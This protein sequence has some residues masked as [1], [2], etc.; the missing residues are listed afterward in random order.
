MIAQKSAKLASFHDVVPP[1][2]RQIFIRASSLGAA[3]SPSQCHHWQNPQLYNARIANFF[4]KRQ[5][6]SR[7]ADLLTWGRFLIFVWRLI[8]IDDS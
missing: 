8:E 1:A 4:R 6:P 7:S 2:K 5:E 3:T